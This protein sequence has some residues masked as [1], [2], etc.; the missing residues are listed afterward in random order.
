MDY[1]SGIS[2][3]RLTE[4][5]QETPLKQKVDPSKIFHGYDTGIEVSLILY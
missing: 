5:L 1:I 3:H 2:L 4:L